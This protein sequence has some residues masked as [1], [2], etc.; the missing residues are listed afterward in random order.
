VGGSRGAVII[1]R[2]VRFSP[3]LHLNIGIF[4]YVFLTG[5]YAAEETLKMRRLSNEPDGSATRLPEAHCQSGVV[6]LYLSHEI[7]GRSMKTP[8]PRSIPFKRPLGNTGLQIGPLVLGGNVFGWTVDQ[9]T[10][11]ELLGLFVDAGPNAVDTSDA[12]SAW[13]PGHKG[14]ESETV[15]G[16]WFKA[17]LSR[18]GKTVLITKVGMPLGAGSGG[19]SSKHIVTAVEDSLRRL[20]TDYIDLYLSHRPDAETPIEETLGAYNRNSFESGLRDLCM[21]EGLGVITYYALASGF[22]T[23]KYRNKNDLGQSARGGSIDKYLNPRGLRILDALDAVAHVHGAQSAEV[24]LA[25]RDQPA[26]CCEC[27][28]VISDGKSADRWYCWSRTSSGAN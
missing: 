7:D 4:Q 8:N 28:G 5:L 17:D 3:L 9:P 24:A 19:L 27:P 16:N 25:W 14:G 10:S 21:A 18:R 2:L 6:S 23:G 1:R 22:L 13:V 12:Y 20:Q 11:F 15:L 26:Q